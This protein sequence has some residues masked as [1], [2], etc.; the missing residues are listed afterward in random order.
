MAY[1][2]R[3]A[4][5]DLIAALAAEPW[6]FDFFQALRLI[7]CLH[8]NKPRLGTSVKA[9]D[10]PVRLAQEPEMDFAPAAL[11]AFEPGDPSRLSVRCLGLF[12]PNGPLPL[13]LTDYAQTRI[14]QHKDP[15]FARFAD[16]FHHRMLSLF[17]RA[18]A[19][20]RPVVGYDRPESDRFGDYI[21]A[22]F[23][24]GME[25]QR[26]R[27]AMLDPAKFYF[28]GLLGCQTRHADGLAAI[29]GEFFGLAVDV[30][31]FVGEW[32]DIPPEDQTRLGVSARIATLGA[33]TVVGARVWGCQHKFRIV[34]GAMAI[35]RYRSLLPGQQGLQEL[36]AIVRNYIGDELVWDVNLIL[37][38]DDVPSLE[39]DGG[40]QLGWTSWLGERVGETD[41]RDLLL[42]PFFHASG[43][44][45]AGRA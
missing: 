11:A 21:G 26:N 34:L 23:G 36:V 9:S 14:R 1:P 28:T 8:K 3:T 4:A 39:L 45:A 6:R 32:M 17:Y 38:H 20:A 7:E 41:A 2:D 15:T 33:S 40:A 35:E 24:I 30:E 19:N 29:I 43:T 16:I 10:D 18:W 5:H 31:E 12:G 22:L 25:S 37:R 44:Y 13:H 27:D 42:N